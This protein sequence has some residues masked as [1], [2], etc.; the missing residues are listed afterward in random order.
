MTF[1][2][3]GGYEYLWTISDRT[4]GMLNTREGETV[5]YTSI[6]SSSASG[7]V[8]TVTVTGFIEG[9]G[10][11]TTASNQTSYSASAE[12]YVTHY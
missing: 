10:G 3:S 9:Q 12:A 11:G 5:V 7:M 4:L 2:A 6:A 8:Q 1:T